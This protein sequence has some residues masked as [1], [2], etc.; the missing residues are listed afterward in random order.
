MGR[1]SI[2]AACTLALALAACA[3]GTA[4]SRAGYD[5]NVIARDDLARR[6]YDNMHSI[7]SSLRPAWLRPPLTGSGIGGQS[8]TAPPTIYLDGRM[9][10]NLDVLKSFSAESIERARYFTAT[11]AQSRFGSQVSSPV[12]EL[13][14]RGRSP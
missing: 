11:E 13:T 6:S 7:V 10:G 14:S 3:T 9:L 2:A 5:P 12:I 1:T 8:A 4:T